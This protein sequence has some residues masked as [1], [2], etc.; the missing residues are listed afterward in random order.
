MLVLFLLTAGGVCCGTGP[1]DT[2]RVPVGFGAGGYVLPGCDADTASLLPPVYVWQR[3]LPA[4]GTALPLLVGTGTLFVEPLERANV[5]IR[6]E[7]QIVRWRR[8]EHRRFA[9]DNGLQFL[10]LASVVGLGLLGVPARHETLPRLS[11][12][13]SAVAVS[14]LV[15]QSLKHSITKRRPSGVSFNTFPSGHSAFAFCGAELL[16]LE[17]GHTS[18]WIPAA[19]YG[20]ALLTGA[21]RVYNDNHWTGD[22]L[23]GAA[24]GVLAADFADL[25]NVWL[26]DPLWRRNRQQVN[27]NEP[28]LR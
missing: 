15:V 23:A 26:L 19:G 17:Y 9:F 13:V 28:I 3:P 20:V 7:V 8:F 24:I 16:R 21:M 27:A 22:V 18:A 10:P 5:L 2:L 1:G 12:S 6:E 4:V 11:R 14:S 25:L